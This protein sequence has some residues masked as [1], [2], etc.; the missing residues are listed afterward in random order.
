M[1][2]G[3]VLILGLVMFNIFASDLDDVEENNVIRTPCSDN[4]TML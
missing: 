4:Y 1:T 3:I 2:W